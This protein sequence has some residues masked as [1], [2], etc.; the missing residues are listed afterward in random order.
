VA[1]EDE[2]QPIK[3]RAE[4]GLSALKIISKDKLHADDVKIIRGEA[5]VL[6]MLE[7][8]S[9]IVQLKNVSIF[10]KRL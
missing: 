4:G 2:M 9:H 6:E 10:S 5:K 7:G 8:L 3:S 1:Q